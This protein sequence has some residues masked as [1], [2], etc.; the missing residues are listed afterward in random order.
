VPSLP[1]VPTDTITCGIEARRIL[2]VQEIKAKP[3][4]N[5]SVGAQLG[6]D[7]PSTPFNPGTYACQVL[8]LASNA[9]HTVGG[10]FRKA[11][12]NVDG[13]NFYGR[14]E[15][16]TAWTNL[17]RFNATPFTAQVTLTTGAPESWEF[18]AMAVIVRPCGK[19][20][21]AELR[22]SQPATRKRLRFPTKMILASAG[23]L[24]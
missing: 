3:G 1:A 13:I 15:G 11:G 21:G 2:W 5:A 14:K 24:R 7:K 6:I 20:R 18:Y 10:K 17:G 8:N 16:A 9:P 4:Y 23:L 19:K 12:G 22:N